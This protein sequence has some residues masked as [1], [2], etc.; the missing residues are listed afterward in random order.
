MRLYLKDK[1]EYKAYIPI[2]KQSD[3]S[4]IIEKLSS[5][6][7][8]R[9]PM[10]LHVCSLAHFLKEEQISVIDYSGFVNIERVSPDCNFYYFYGG[11]WEKKSEGLYLFATV[12]SWESKIIEGMPKIQGIDKKRWG[13]N[14]ITIQPY[15]EEPHS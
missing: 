2:E 9:L 11:A 13:K 4:G 10:K 6:P 5:Q 7:I 14:I 15:I 8:N 3:I 12:P 1:K